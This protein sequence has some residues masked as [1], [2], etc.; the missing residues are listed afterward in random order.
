MKSIEKILD[1][2]CTPSARPGESYV[3]SLKSV[4]DVTIERI[5][6]YHQNI[7]YHIYVDKSS[8]FTLNNSKNFQISQFISAL[9]KV[10]HNCL[11]CKT[12]DSRKSPQT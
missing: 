10:L 4:L 8:T 3:T 1:I 7:P 2:T 9:Q 11:T 5:E 6:T 12:V